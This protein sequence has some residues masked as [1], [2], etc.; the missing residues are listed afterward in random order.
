ME[1][2]TSNLN[3]EIMEEDLNALPSLVVLLVD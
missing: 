1:E 2:E 3:L